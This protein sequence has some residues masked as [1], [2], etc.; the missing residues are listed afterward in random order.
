ME[1]KDEVSRLRLRESWVVKVL[2][3]RPI[4][5]AVM[6]LGWLNRVE[7]FPEA[8]CVFYHATFQEYFAALAV[9]DWDDFLPRNHVNFPV[10]GKEYRIFEPQ[11]KQVILLWLGRGDVVNEE[12]EKFI[13]KLVDFDDGCGEWNFEKVDRGFYEY[14]AYFLA[15]AGISEFKAC[16]L[17][18]EIVRQVVK[19]KF[20]YFNVQKQEW[21]S[22]LE[23]PIELR[24]GKLLLEMSRQLATREIIAILNHSTDALTLGLAAYYLK[25]IDPQNPYNR[26]LITSLIEI[27]EDS[28]NNETIRLR[29]LYRLRK[30]AP[31]NDQEVISALMLV[32]KNTENDE[33]L[34]EVV[35]HYLV[36]ITQED[37][38][39]IIDAL[40]QILNNAENEYPSN[41]NATR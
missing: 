23:A 1:Q 41:S 35:A 12:K 33:N 38:G 16:S 37:Q 8:I 14:R 18:D 5:Q 15:A 11:W 24:T 36:G 25:E 39:A 21:L 29:T 10:A 2:G 13:E 17:A 28:S 32:L 6:K 3:S 40:I 7:R 27:I 20:G 30:I 34:R 22:F 9:D 31:P 26:Q 19:W 4:F